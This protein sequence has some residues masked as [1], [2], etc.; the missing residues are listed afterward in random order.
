MTNSSLMPYMGGVAACLFLYSIHALLAP[1]L[2]ALVVAYLLSPVVSSMKHVPRSI[3]SLIVVTGF[4]LCLIALALIV[5]PFLKQH[6][7]YLINK[8]PELNSFITQKS[9]PWIKI[10]SDSIGVDAMPELQEQLSKHFSEILQWF[11]NFIPSLLNKGMAIANVLSYFILM[12]LSIFYLLRDW[13][14]FM[15]STLKLIPKQYQKTVV[16]EAVQIHETLGTL[17]HGQ[18]KIALILMV[19]YA[20]SLY[21]AGLG[22]QGIFVGFLTGLLSFIPYL[23]MF[24]GYGMAIS[25]SITHGLGWDN[26]TA[27]S[28][29]FLIISLIEGNFLTPKY[30][31]S[32]I[33]VHPLFILMGLW[34]GWS[35]F[36]MAGIILVMPAIAALSVLVRH[37]ISLYTQTKFY[38]D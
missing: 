11:I 24:L 6:L 3:A 2:I 21:M 25:V 7:V 20:I 14:K 34:V 38:K 5:T 22:H 16:N 33:G 28:I 9:S 29:I 27:I 35:L 19:L 26:V 32:K 36:G 17:I 37:G 10:V 30:V 1:F 8:I 4:I 12:P 31:G 18:L 23:G 13:K 15:S